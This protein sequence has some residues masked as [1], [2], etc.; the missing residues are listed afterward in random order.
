MK[1]K[2]VIEFLSKC[3]P[4]AEFI[5]EDRDGNNHALDELDSGACF[6]LDEESGMLMTIDCVYAIFKEERFK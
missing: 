5:S 4:N 6:H 1:V 2:D 3:N